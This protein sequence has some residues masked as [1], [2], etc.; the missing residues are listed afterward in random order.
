MRSCCSVLSP[1]PAL[2]LLTGGNER[3]KGML[4]PR[5][6]EKGGQSILVV[7]PHYAFGSRPSI[8]RVFRGAS[9]ER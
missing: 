7:G 8:L 5:L 6:I 4:T 9:S 1:T 3:F 2:F